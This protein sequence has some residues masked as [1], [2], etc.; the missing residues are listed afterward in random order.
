MS[1][2]FLHSLSI[3]NHWFFE[4]FVAIIV[5]LISI[6]ILR[7]FEKFII[8]GLRRFAKKTDFKFDDVL[9]AILD[10][11]GWPLYILIAFYI[12]FK[13]IEVPQIVSEYFPTLLYI[14]IVYYIVKAIGVL[15]DFLSKRALEK[16]EADGQ[17]DNP[18]VR[19]LAK[20][21]KIILWAVALITVLRSLGYNISTIATTLGIGGIAV[22]FALQ[23]ILSDIFASFSIYIDKPF[24]PGDFIVISSDM[25]TVKTIGIKSTRIQ[26]LTG[27]ELVI[28]N[29]EL[30]E[31]R[32][33]NF[34]ILNKRRVS[35]N[36]VLSHETPNAKLRKLPKLI[37][38]GMKS[39]KLVE[40]YL[41]YFK[42]YGKYGLVYEIIFYI[43]SPDYAK[44]TQV[45]E[46][47]NL[48]IK[49]ILEKEKIG[50]AFKW[51]P[52][53]SRNTV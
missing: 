20:F 49:S 41:V 32:I 3:S 44:Y 47:I 38:D 52:F 25:G 28:S 22:A 46:K 11:I 9:A 1:F 7:L 15:I 33:H 19:L 35:F 21:S 50:F 30:T 45:K 51:K 23:N 37:K 36:I 43:T 42:E 26:S 12:S 48:K 13:F 53:N 14:V 4:Y 40:P 27:E 29:K 34:G 2:Q 10:S 8:H 5:F 31:A 24:K 18:G 39:V 17:L 16:D 6:L